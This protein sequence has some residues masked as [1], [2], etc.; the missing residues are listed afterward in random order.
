[1]YV[2]EIKQRGVE[3]YQNYTL[4]SHCNIKTSKSVP[5]HAFPQT[6]MTVGKESNQKVSDMEVVYRPLSI[7]ISLRINFLFYLA[8]LET[9]LYKKTCGVD[10]LHMPSVPSN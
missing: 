4:V 2:H 6:K 1:M 5:N 3:L 9:T 7:L 8:A 10:Q